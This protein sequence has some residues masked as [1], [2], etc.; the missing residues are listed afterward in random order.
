MSL[1]HRVVSGPGWGRIAEGW[2]WGLVGGTLEGTSRR[3][4]DSDPERLQRVWQ[5]GTDGGVEGAE[6]WEEVHSDDASRAA[7]CS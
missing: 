4:V 5:E 3:K 7:G 1:V 2:A 6:S